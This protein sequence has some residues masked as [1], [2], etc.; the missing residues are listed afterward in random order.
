[1]ASQ[2]L[3]FGGVGGG[4]KTNITKIVKNGQII[5]RITRGKDLLYLHHPGIK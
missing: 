4:V 1:M 5:N 2:H 3:M